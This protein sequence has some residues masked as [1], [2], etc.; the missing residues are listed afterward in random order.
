MKIRLC[1]GIAAL[2]MIWCWGAAVLYA[3]PPE[4]EWSRTYGG[5]SSDA[6]YSTHQTIDGGYVFAGET[7]SFSSN[8][9]VYLVK[10]DSLG[11]SL[12]YRL[13][14][15]EG[16]EEVYSIEL[17]YDNGYILTGF[18]TSF[19]AG[20]TDM[21]LIKTDSQ[22]D[23]LWTH[24]YGGAYSERAR[25]VKQTSDNG[26]ILAGYTQPSSGSLFDMYLVKTDS[27]GNTL[28]TNSYGGFDDRAA[29]SVQQTRDGGYIFVGYNPF[30]GGVEYDIYLVK[31]DST[32]DTLWT[33]TFGGNEPDR[34]YE[35]LRTMDDGYVI[36]GNTES[37]G[38]G[39]SDFYIIK[40]DSLGDTL[41]TRT[42]GGDMGEYARSIRQT[43]DGGYIIAGVT[44]SFGAENGDM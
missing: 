38:S 37:F 10:T 30:A 13:I 18:T 39:F 8:P 17:T 43:H 28:W 34:A 32:G 5:D 19:G 20:S 36:A 4:I 44:G 12:W 3:Q 2:V 15:G 22:G 35:V 7:R 31:T 40:T 29:Y 16:Y 41:W 26:Y 1:G 33:R 21:Y 6:A 11:Y 42:Y 27:I 25:S 24:T 9:D 14:G 23:T